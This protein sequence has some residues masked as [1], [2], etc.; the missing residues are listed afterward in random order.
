MSCVAQAKHKKGEYVGPDGVAILVDS[1]KFEDGM[2]TFYYSGSKEGVF[3]DSIN[4]L[5][6]NIATNATSITNLENEANDTAEVYDYALRKYVEFNVQTGT[7]YTLVLTDEAKIVTLD[8]G[9]AIALTIPTNASVAFELGTQITLV[10]LGAGIVTVG[11]GGVTIRSYDNDYVLAG[12]YA[13]VTII[14]QAT[15]TWLLM[16]NL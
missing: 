4:I 9:S 15:D 5:N 7:S 1:I 2:V 10:Q 13:I 16:G 12:Q 11:G 3:N 6:I 14:K 8:N